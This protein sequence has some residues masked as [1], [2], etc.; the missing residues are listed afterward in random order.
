MDKHGDDQQ[1]ANLEQVVSASRNDDY[2]NQRDT[3]H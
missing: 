3:R 1:Q 2:K